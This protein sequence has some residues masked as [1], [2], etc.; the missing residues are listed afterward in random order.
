MATPAPR[1]ARLLLPLA[2]YAGILALSSIPGEE[3]VRV[4]WAEGLSYLAHAVEYAVLGAALRWAFGPRSWS[5]SVTV[6]LGLLAGLGDEWFQSTVP[7][8]TPSAVDLAVDLVGV[9][10]G[11]TLTHRRVRRRR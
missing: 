10:A 1:F 6:A 3:I 4:P 11:A 7:G 8:R 9:T 2:C 5:L